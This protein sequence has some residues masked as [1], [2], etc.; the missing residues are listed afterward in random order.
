MNI[1]WSCKP[2]ASLSPNELYS[3]LQ[4]RNEVFVVEQNCVYQDCDD[5][6]RHAHHFMGWKE[7]KLVAYT[8]LLPSG[9]AYEEISI[10]RVVTSPSVRG[11]KT[12]KELMRKSIEKIHELFGRSPIKIGAQ[13]YLKRFYESFGFIQN[14]DV[15]LEDGIDHIKMLRDTPDFRQ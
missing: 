4:L 14:S 12:G 6:D 5:K 3:I 13:L 15:Y 11:S 9:V 7:N 10:G 2:F 8:R 1:T